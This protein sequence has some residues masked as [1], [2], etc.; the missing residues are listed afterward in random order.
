MAQRLLFSKFLCLSTKM[1]FTDPAVEV[2]VA[3]PNFQSANFEKLSYDLTA[4]GTRKCEN[5]KTL[6]KRSYQ[7]KLSSGVAVTTDEG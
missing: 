2:A 1:S 5:A 7:S 3:R 6:E 4:A